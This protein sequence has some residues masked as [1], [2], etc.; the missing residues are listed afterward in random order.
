MDQYYL[1]TS[2][3]LPYYREELHSR[4]VQDF[5]L[6]LSA[7]VAI[8][9]LTEVE[10]ASALSR[11]VRM[12]EIDDA[13]AG[14]IEQA[15][16]EDRM[17]GLFKRVS[18]TVAHYNQ[19]IKWLSLRN[20]SLRALDTLHLAVSHYGNLKIVTCDEIL[21]K[22]AEKLGAACYYLSE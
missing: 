20:T 7:P 5:L 3:I 19:A 13:Q 12:K 22:S 18:F 1:D 8:S 6:S 17:S 4:L 10:F 2:S 16:S 21:S 14:I 9:H 15:F 11:L